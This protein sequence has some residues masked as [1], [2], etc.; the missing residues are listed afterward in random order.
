MDAWIGY[1]IL[2]LAVVAVV[3]LALMI[4]RKV[5]FDDAP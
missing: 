1:V 2:A 3:L 4:I 5:T